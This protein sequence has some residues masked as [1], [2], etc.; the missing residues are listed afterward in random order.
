MDSLRGAW[1]S[2]WDWFHW[3]IHVVA[4]ILHPLWR[5]DKQYENEEL[6]EGWNTYI[7]AYAEGDVQRIGQLEH[8]RLLFRNS[9]TKSLSTATA[10]LR[11]CQLEPISWWEKYGTSTPHLVSNCML[12]FCTWLIIL[13]F[14]WSHKYHWLML[15]FLWLTEETCYENSFTRL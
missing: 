8:E 11:E 10:R 5:D 12:P 3:P 7:V 14:M 13:H 15:T 9:T 1:L 4:H 2:R 6:E